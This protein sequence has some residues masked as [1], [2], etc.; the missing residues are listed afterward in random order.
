MFAASIG[1]FMVVREYGEGLRA[2][3]PPADARPVGGHLT[4]QVD[5][6]RHVIATLAAVVGLGF[7][8]SHIFRR[9]GQP[10]VI[11]EVVA[12]IVLGPSVLGTISPDTLHLLIPLRSSDPQGHVPATLNAVSQLGAILYM[13]LVG[14]E[15]NATRLAGRARA[16]VAVSHTSIVVP[17]VLGMMLARRGYPAR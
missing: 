9:I 1:L 14:L 5:V 7:V 6:L 10:P 13:F 11:G 4:G 12:G 16:V 15:L 8:L 17:F 2:P 3:A